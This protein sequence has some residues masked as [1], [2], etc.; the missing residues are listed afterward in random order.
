VLTTSLSYALPVRLALPIVLIAIAT[1]GL[2]LQATR[3]RQL[4]ALLVE[5]WRDGSSGCG[6]LAAMGGL[7]ALMFFFPVI[8]EGDW[9]LGQAYG[10][11]S[12]YYL[13]LAQRF[14]SE[15]SL[16]VASHEQMSRWSDITSLA[17]SAWLFG[18][19]TRK[20]FAAFGGAF[21]LTVPF[22][23]NALLK[24]L[25]MTAA[26][27]RVGAVLLSFSA[28]WFSLFSQGYLAHYLFVFALAWSAGMTLLCLQVS[29]QL[30]RAGQWA[31]WVAT[32][33][34]YAFSISVYPFQFV[35][36][37]AWALTVALCRRQ[38]GT[39]HAAREL[40][41]VGALTLALTNVSLSIIL[42]FP[43]V[44]AFYGNFERLH[45]L[46]RGLI[47]PFYD[48]F[49]F[50]TIA[51]GLRDFVLN[52]A[53]L[54]ML[55]Y[56]TLALD[57]ARWLRRLVL[58]QRR[59]NT[60]GVLWTWPAVALVLLG[61]GACVWRQRREHVFLAV[62][63]GLF[64]ALMGFHAARGETYAFGKLALTVG[65][66]ALLL[67]LIGL[68]R[69]WDRVQGRGPRVVLGVFAAGFLVLNLA[70]G[71][72]E[73]GAY[74]L[75]RRSA[76]LLELRT[77]VSAIDTPI[78]DLAALV[79]H[80]RATTTGPIKVEQVGMYTDRLQQDDDRVLLWRIEHLALLHGRG[81]AP[82][83]GPVLRVVFN[84]VGEQAPADSQ[85]VQSNDIF[86]V[87]RLPGTGAP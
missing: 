20:V 86:R 59:L 9:Y 17:A 65:V 61:W 14:I 53:Q 84:S 22:L 12:F 51:L 35:L 34:V 82:G 81:T 26:P 31:L 42:F 27:A 60:L 11:V 80:E 38:E 50:V 66:F 75:N 52:S 39:R 30:E 5:A 71:M 76:L 78:K 72:L 1:V 19:D 74:L 43:E 56:E 69:L 40:V 46:A 44:K 36:P 77:H 33:A 54:P 85:E 63:M 28:N 64:V 25:G 37:V 16:D 87:Y 47:F 49:S 45:A 21:W 13:N 79:E 41:W 48:S 55:V 10:D 18:G 32:A 15:R 67:M 58:L 57:S 73:N 23:A 62:T 3:V 70:S 83:P 8:F 6:G 7:S 4:G 68:G 29:P 2:W 24:R